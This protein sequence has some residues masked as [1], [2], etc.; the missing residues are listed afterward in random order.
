MKK[1]SLLV[2]GLLVA[3]TGAA[4]AQNLVQGVSESTDPATAAAVE[5]H[6]AELR[7]RTEAAPAARHAQPRTRMHQGKSHHAKARHHKMHRTGEPAVK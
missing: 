4:F 1:L 7:A 5:Q 6:A 3:M 2:A